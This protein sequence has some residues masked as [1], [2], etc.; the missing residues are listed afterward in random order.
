MKERM[1][2]T[3][4]LMIGIVGL[5]L[6]Q[7]GCGSKEMVMTGFLTDYSRLEKESDS[8]LR[9]VN[10]PA[11]ARYSRF[12]V[13]PVEVHFYEEAKSK[14]KLDDQQL[15]D[16]T[17]YMHS[18]LNQAVMESGNKLTYQPGPGVA[19][20][21]AALTD[22]N[23]T[24]MLNILPQASLLQFGV[25]NV[26]MEVEMIDSETGE[27]IGAVVETRKGSRIPFTNLG[28]WTTARKIMDHWGKRLQERLE[29]VR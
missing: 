19:R 9:Y 8:S 7:S 21:R 22:I 13:D 16:L 29:E 24:S 15:I 10:E 5:L 18:K 6:A 4:A 14:G 17:N 27:Q 25:G 23:K 12:I 2:K 1:T 28:E 20:I 11:L 26:S 3:S